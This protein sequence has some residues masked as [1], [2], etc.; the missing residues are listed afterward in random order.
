M[1]RYTEAYIDEQMAR[2][3][4]WKNTTFMVGLGLLLIGAQAKIAPD[5]DYGVSIIMAGLTYCTASRTVFAISSRT[6]RQ[7]PRAVFDT[8]L[9]VDGAYVIYWFFVDRSALIMRDVQWPVSLCL[10]LMCGLIWLLDDSE[11]LCDAAIST[12]H[13]GTGSGSSSTTVGHESG[14]LSQS[15]QGDSS[16]DTKSS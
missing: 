9:A 4:S 7:W 14:P 16:S 13:L 10:Y 12:R 2:L 6:L 11:A 8:W 15:I 1:F 3:F 5:W